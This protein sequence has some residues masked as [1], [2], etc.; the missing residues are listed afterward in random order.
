MMSGLTQ[1]AELI[2]CARCGTDVE[3]TDTRWQ[4]VWAC[5]IF[6][7]ECDKSLTELLRLQPVP[8]AP[9]EYF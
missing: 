2:P 5:W 1:I 7:D 6:C 4:R 9:G 3:M 8:Y